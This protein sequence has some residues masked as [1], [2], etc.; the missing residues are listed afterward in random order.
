[1]GGMGGHFTRPDLAD[2]N[3]FF[4]KSFAEFRASVRHFPRV[5]SP[6]VSSHPP[7]AE[8]MRFRILNHVFDQKVK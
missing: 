6:P 8:N 7:M 5:K 4:R 3:C 2:T 1:M